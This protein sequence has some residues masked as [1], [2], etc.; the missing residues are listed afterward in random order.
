LRT[1]TV[2]V[3]GIALLLALSGCATTVGTPSSACAPSVSAGTASN[4]ISATGDFGTKPTVSFPTPL[5]TTKTQ[6]TTTIDG[7]G[8]PLADGQKVLVQLSLYDGRT[9]DFVAATKYK[10]TAS[11]SG[12][13]VNH[14]STFFEGAGKALLCATPGSRVA[15]AISAADATKATGGISSY[16]IKASDSLVLVADIVKA[17]LP[18]AEGKALAPINGFPT[19]ITTTKNRPGVHVSDAAAPTTVE[20]ETLIR[21]TGA[22]VKKGQ[23]VTAHVL[24]VSW[25]DTGTAVKNT[26]A[27]HNPD[28]IVIGKATDGKAV[29]AAVEGATIGSRLVVV[30]P[31]SAKGSSASVYV[32]DILG[33]DETPAS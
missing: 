33:A 10:G 11:A 27:D 13:I 25:P 23:T 20:D 29:D 18:N 3:S 4:A 8:A 28:T 30:A 14:T 12:L 1:P 21:G 16:G 24:E 17:Y 15:M 2:V 31:A 5:T 6:V 26:W 7:S 19:V 22:V 32:I 9:G